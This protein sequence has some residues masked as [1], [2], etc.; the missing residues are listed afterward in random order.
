MFRKWYSPEGVAKAVLTG[1][2]VSLGMVNSG[3]D[4]SFP[5]ST[6][7]HIYPEHGVCVEGGYFVQFVEVYTKGYRSVQLRHKHRGC[8]T[9]VSPLI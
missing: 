9:L 6:Y 2:A 4:L 5:H 1:S 3:K 8:R 7:K